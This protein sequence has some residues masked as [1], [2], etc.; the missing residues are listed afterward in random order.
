MILLKKRI[1]KVLISLHG[2]AGWSV[3]LLFAHTEDRFPCIEA[4]LKNT[5]V[6]FCS[7][8]SRKCTKYETCTNLNRFHIL[9]IYSVVFF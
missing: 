5:I 7:S 8:S 2:Y 3:P 6:F 9:N 4:H 1:V